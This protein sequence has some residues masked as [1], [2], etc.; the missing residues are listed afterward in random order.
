VTREN[1]ISWGR[2]ALVAVLVAAAWFTWN[3]PVAYPLRILVTFLHEFSHAIGGV[4]T[5]GHIAGVAVQPDGSGVCY[6]RGGWRIVIL[7]AG[8]IGSMV[9]GC[10]ITITALRTRSGKYLSLLLGLGLMLMTLFYVRTVFSFLYG[11]AIGAALASAGW[12]LPKPEN[13]LL[14]S[15]IG[16]TSCL[17]AIFDIRTLF[18]IGG[19]VNNDA[20]MFSK[21]IFPLPPRVWAVLW[22][23]IAL[24]VL[25]LALKAAVRKGPAYG[26]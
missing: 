14:L 19:T 5:G 12:W 25:W 6:T 10:L 22:G 23:A 20:V 21:E 7:P 2:L 3:K 15:F 24:V 17:N 13:D 1:G 26:R 9:W 11:L 18:E 4:L 16:V 8:Y